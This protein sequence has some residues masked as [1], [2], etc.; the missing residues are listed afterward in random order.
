[1]KETETKKQIK[2]KD[3]W[4]PVT[5]AVV[6]ALTYEIFVFPN[7]FAPAGINGFGTMIQYLFHFSVGYFSLL[8]NVPLFLLAWRYIDRDFAVKSLTFVLTFSAA[9]LHFDHIDLSEWVY[10]ES[11]GNSAILGPIVAGVIAG[12]VYSVALSHNGSTGGTDIIAAWIRTKNPETNLLWTLFLL[13]AVIAILSFFVYGH[14][15]EPVVMCL[16]YC[17]LSALISDTYLK[18]V[19]RAYKYEVITNDAEALADELMQ[20]LHHGVTVLHGEGMYLKSDRELLICVV[21]H[22]QVVAFRRIL[23]RHPDAFAYVSI[24]TETVGNFKKI[25]K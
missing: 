11:N 9:I 8:I 15:Y 24:V 7:A 12:G 5:M 16:I 25:T 13:N 14:K 10:F 6:L 22:H 23:A 2:V 21:N 1:M 20:E 18:G 17:F 3:L 4:V 19:K